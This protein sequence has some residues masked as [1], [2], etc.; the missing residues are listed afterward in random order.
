MCKTDSEWEAAMQ[1]RV[2]S[3]VLSDHLEG[4]D[5]GLGERIKKEGIY[6]CT[7]TYT[8]TLTHTHTYG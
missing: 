3:Q 4:W 8:H 2:P 5:G 1:H 6:I 7:H